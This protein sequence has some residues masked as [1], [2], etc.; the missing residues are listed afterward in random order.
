MKN[1]QIYDNGAAFMIMVDGMIV[2]G[3]NTLGAAWKH[4]EWMYRIACQQFTVGEKKTP[5]TEWI[6]S[7]K[8]VGA[9]D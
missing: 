1:V 8:K 4:I 5:V 2:T 6:A 7:M 9:L 3:F